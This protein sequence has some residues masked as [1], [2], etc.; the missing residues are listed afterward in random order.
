METRFVFHSGLFLAGMTD[1]ESNPNKFPFVAI[2]ENPWLKLWVAVWVLGVHQ[3]SLVNSDS[4]ASEVSPNSPLR[5]RRSK[6]ITTVISGV[7]SR[8]RIEAKA[9]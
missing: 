6:Y 9:M 4:S 7:M 5:A 2:S 8:P 1:R 3:L